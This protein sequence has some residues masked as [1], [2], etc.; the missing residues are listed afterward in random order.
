MDIK[1]EAFQRV[2]ADAEQKA[3]EYEGAKIVV[4]GQEDLLKDLTAELQKQI[5]HVNNCRVC[6]D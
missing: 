3:R 4:R 2:R 6:N 5:E 1:R